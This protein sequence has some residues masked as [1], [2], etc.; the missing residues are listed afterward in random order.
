MK[1]I[2]TIGLDIAKWVFQV[3]GVDD[4]GKVVVQKQLARP[5]MLDW[6]SKLSPCLIG[7]EACAT[8]NYWARE[9]SRLGHDVRLIPPAY[10]KAYVRRQ[11]N[12]R[13]DAAAICE[14]VS[15]PSMRFATLKTM[16]QQMVQVLHRTRE[17]LIKQRVQLGNALR[18]HLAEFGAIFPQGAAGLDKAIAFIKENS[19]DL[20][21]ELMGILRVY[22]EQITRI[23]ETIKSLERD[24]LLWHRSQGDSLRLA[25][26]PGIG[27][28]TASAIVAA[29]G[30][31]KQFQSGRE[32]AAWRGLVPRQNSSGGNQLPPLPK[33]LPNSLGC[34]GKKNDKGTAIC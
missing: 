26:I 5:E 3:H 6:F 27:T 1:N 16:P 13:A 34:V 11:K 9:L 31:G 10:V 15:R 33:L 2:S 23:R 14:A 28:V 22:V 4:A 32:F 12:D 21:E 7:L 17:L 8:A 24:M 20:P 30:D 29:I 19:G 25:T 18:A